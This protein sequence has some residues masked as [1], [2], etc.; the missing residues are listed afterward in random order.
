MRRLSLLAVLALLAACGDGGG[1]GDDIPSIERM[2]R[3][4]VQGEVEDRY[5]GASR[6]RRVDCVEHENGEGARCIA[7][8]RIE[9]VGSE[10]WG[11]IYVPYGTDDFP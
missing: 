6:V 8:V 1:G 9:G 10:R 11:G 4:F 7:H 5:G 3:D 2:V